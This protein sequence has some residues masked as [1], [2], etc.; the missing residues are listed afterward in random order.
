M[1]KIW[2]DFI[3]GRGAI[4]LLILRVLIGAAMMQH[5]WGKIQSPFNWMD[6]DPKRGASG[7]PGILQF[8]A[9]LSEF[10]GG[11][12]LIVGFLT[13]LACLGILATMTVAI[14]MVGKGQPWI[15][16][17]P[18][19]PSFESASLYWIPAAA[20]L[21]TGPGIYSLDAILFQKERRVSSSR[22]SR[23]GVPDSSNEETPL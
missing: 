7:V 19:A 13:P 3:A 1:Q 2:G 12:A 8:L 15:A 18:G 20:L 10:G 9:A 17:K 5:G 4:G 23:F 6:L 21:F 22:L 11:A 14:L 16:S